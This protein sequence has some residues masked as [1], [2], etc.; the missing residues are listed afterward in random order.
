MPTQRKFRALM[1]D[2]SLGWRRRAQLYDQ[3]VDSLPDNYRKM[4]LQYARTGNNK[5]SSSSSSSSTS[6]QNGSDMSNDPEMQNGTQDF[7]N[8]GPS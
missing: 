2:R 8:N 5:S 1:V 6:E 3:L 4:M 7:D